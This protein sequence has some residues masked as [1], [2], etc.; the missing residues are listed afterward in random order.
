MQR[1]AEALVP[2]VEDGRRQGLARRHA[3]PQ[4]GQI[5]RLG[6]RHLEEPRVHGG[7][8]EEHGGAFG[9]DD[10]EDPGGIEPLGHEQ[11]RRSHPLGKVERVAQ[12]EGEVHLGDRERD[13]VGTD[14][15]DADAD[16]IGGGHEVA[17]R[18]DSGLGKSGR[19]RRVAPVQDVLVDR[20]GRGQLTRRLGHEAG[21]LVGGEDRAKPGARFADLTDDPRR[22]RLGDDHPG[23]A[24]VEQEGVLLA[25]H[26]RVDGDGDSTELRRTPERRD[27]RGRV[28]GGEEH[29]LLDLKAEAGQRLT[30]T[31][32]R[33]GD[34]GA[35]DGPAAMAKGGARAASLG[36]V[37]VDEEGGSVET[38]RAIVLHGSRRI[39]T[40]ALTRP[41]WRSVA[42]PSS[43]VA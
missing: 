40:R 18:V 6:V 31:V 27:E 26:Q 14:A 43:P 4:R 16:Q 1:K 22:R 28:V 23:A 15:E 21:E 41:T 5:A 11:G 37:A 25:P 32:D 7:D 42:G 12:T 33:L 24:V 3:E 36:H 9:L 35:G 10:V 34:V 38:H 2:G 29:S 13:V 20:G 8:G 19:A 39:E 17:M 30:G